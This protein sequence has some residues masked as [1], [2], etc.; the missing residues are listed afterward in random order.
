MSKNEFT[1]THSPR[2]DYLLLSRGQ[3]DTNARKE[4]VEAAIAKFYAWY[5]RNV[6]SGQLKPC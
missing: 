4:D 3:W 6:K 1:H 5:E 2:S